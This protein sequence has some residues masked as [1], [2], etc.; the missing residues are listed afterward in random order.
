MALQAGA[1]IALWMH[2]TEVPAVL[3]RLEAAV[4]TGEL[5]IAAVDQ[6]LVRTA[7]VKGRSPKCGR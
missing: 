1:D 2:T 7:V 5:N 4:N 3:D 6:K